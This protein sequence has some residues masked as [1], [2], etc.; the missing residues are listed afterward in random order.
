MKCLKNN[1]KSLCLAV[2]FITIFVNLIFLIH[3]LYNGSLWGTYSGDVAGKRTE[4]SFDGTT[5][6]MSVE[7]Q[8]HSHG[9]YG[10]EKNA[11]MKYGIDGYGFITLDNEAKWGMWNIFSINSIGYEE[12]YTAYNAGAIAIQVVMSV[13]TFASFSIFV[14]IKVKEY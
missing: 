4:I 1:L 8:A 13:I 5:Y 7:D 6:Q 9:M 2:M 3:P 10:Y 11:D 12:E 14:F